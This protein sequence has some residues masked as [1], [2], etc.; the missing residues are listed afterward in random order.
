MKLTYQ[1]IHAL[2]NVGSPNAPQIKALG[3]SCP[4]KK[5][6]LVGLIGREI[7]QSEYDRL[8]ALKGPRPKGIPSK[9]WRQGVVSPQTPKKEQSPELENY[10]G[11]S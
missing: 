7:D 9:E 10:L 2:F 5:G 8:L 4:L 6:W 1:T 11:F 3:L